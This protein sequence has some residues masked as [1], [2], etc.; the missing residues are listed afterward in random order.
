MRVGGL[1]K[2]AII[3]S[4][5]WAKKALITLVALTIVLAGFLWIMSL[6]L[7]ARV[8]VYLAGNGRVQQYKNW[9]IAEGTWTRSG[10]LSSSAMGAPLQTSRIQ[11]SLREHRCTEARASISNRVLLSELIE[12]EIE[13]WSE[14]T[15]V[16]KSEA[17]CA[18][19]V[20][21]IDLKTEVI[22]GV[23]HPINGDGEFCKTYVE[24]FANGKE[25][26]W[27]YR[28]VDGF[29]VYWEEQK[30]ARPL[31]LRLIV[32]LFGN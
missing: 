25:A 21:T 26:R 10:S 9:I 3:F 27:N 20:F 1:Q 12:Y 29:Q 2:L 14:T 18:I 7:D 4:V 19:E 30:K 23:G 17:R 15:V 6:Y 13:S 32:T 5:A 8:P 31:P 16:L 28:L 24:Q 11:C 22:N